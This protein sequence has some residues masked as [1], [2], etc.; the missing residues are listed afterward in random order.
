MA[1]LAPPVPAGTRPQQRDNRSGRAGYGRAD[2]V[3]CP[4]IC[5]RTLSRSQ[6][7]Y[8]PAS[9]H[10]GCGRFSRAPADG[11]YR[12]RQTGASMDLRLIYALLAIRHCRYLIRWCRGAAKS[13][14]IGHVAR[15]P[16]NRALGPIQPNQ[17]CAKLRLRV[18]VSR[19][20]F[21]ILAHQLPATHTGL[22]PAGMRACLAGIA[23]RQRA[24]QRANRLCCRVGHGLTSRSSRAAQT[25]CS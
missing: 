13:E 12:R 7:S 15:G 11:H 18:N 23:S 20:G 24:P 17:N 9:G 5:R 1:R 22:N 8:F 6:V 3:R 4:G 16:L 14:I 21:A 19:D 25:R 2:R 10:Y